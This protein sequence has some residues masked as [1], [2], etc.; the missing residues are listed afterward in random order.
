MD[1][2][3][4]NHMNYCPNCGHDLKKGHEKEHAEGHEP[5]GEH[6]IA[7]AVVGQ[8]KKNSMKGEKGSC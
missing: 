1:H 3:P 8:M 6:G 5:P 7:E 4:D 2:K